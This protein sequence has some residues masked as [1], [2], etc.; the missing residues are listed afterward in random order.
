MAKSTQRNGAPTTASRALVLERH[1]DPAPDPLVDPGAWRDWVDGVGRPTIVDLFCGAGG[2]S[3]GATQ[4][5]GEVILAV[6]ND[7]QALLTHAAHFRGAAMCLDLADEDNLRRLVELL[8]GVHV[9]VLVGG[10][11]CQPFSKAGRSKIRS[12][13]A[14][15]ARGE[16]DARR[17][18]WRPF[19]D[20]VL[21]VRPA[22]VIFE[23]VTE[24]ALADES[25][26][27]RSIV[28]DFE[29]DGY[30][31]DCRLID[32]WRFGVPQFR[33]RCIIVA[34]RDG[35]ACWPE[36]QAGELVSVS[37]AVDDLPLLRS[38]TGARRM[39]YR[40]ARTAFQRAAR[41]GVAAG[42]VSVVYDHVGRAVRD[43]DRQAFTLL[44]PTTRY[45]DLPGNLKRYRDDIFRDKYH[46]LDGAGLSR[47]ITAHIA[48]DGYGFIHPTEPRSLTVREAARLQTFPD[49]FRFAGS[50]SSAYAQIGNAVPPRLAEALIGVLL[51]EPAAAGAK[52]G[53]RREFF[54]MVAT[55]WDSSRGEVRQDGCPWAALVSEVCGRSRSGRAAAERVLDA[56]ATVGDASEDAL[57]GLRDSGGSAAFVKAVGRCAAAAGAVRSD[58]WDTN[59]W[60]GAAGLRPSSARWVRTVGLNSGEVHAAAGACR[61]AAR[62]E[63]AD[64]RRR[65]RG[66]DRVL[67]AQLLG[68]DASGGAVTA[69]VVRLSEV[70]CLLR[71]PACSTCPLRAH[72]R[73]RS[74]ISD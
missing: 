69:A 45:V 40:S 15:G 48:K 11:P 10:P 21:A 67:L 47:T 8:S 70:H 42:D 61:V 32:G 2:L 54:R 65:S 73:G 72:C 34:R 50:R 23:N 57:S 59:T 14:G 56:C 19:V 20:V 74:P 37:D 29:A 58:G 71:S 51:R 5:G 12:L 7:R 35:P 30:D 9:D 62:F 1:T 16:L 38:G 28:A 49:W 39:P 26:V 27:M 52:S 44:S 55:S 4:A 33:R 6:D 46:R 18:L 13:V 66:S 22:A 53:L 43:D 60:V 63:G 64:E 41:E 25:H 24:V 31:T 17:A 68:C 3:L 36:E